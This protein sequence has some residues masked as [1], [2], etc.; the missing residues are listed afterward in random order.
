[1]PVHPD[2]PTLDSAEGRELRSGLSARAKARIAGALYLIIIVGGAFA[3]LGVRERLVVSGDAAATAHNIV[4]HELLYRLGFAIEVFYLLCGVPLKFLLYDLFRVV[5]RNVALVMVL[6]AAIGA[7]I[8]GVMMLA[9]Y[10]PLLFLGGAGYLGAFSAAQLQAAAYL[11]LRLFDYGYMI[12]LAF[13]GCFCLLIGY[14]I[15][16]STFFPRLV[17]PLLAIEG[18]LYLTNS[19]AHFLA[20]AVG[21]QVYPF[22]KLSGIGEV[23][24][25]L[26]LL[27]VGVNAS[28]WTT[29]AAEQVGRRAPG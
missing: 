20:P 1:M 14:L 8:Q 10:A 15:V 25:C 22:L 3:Q 5:N 7:A 28:R 23:S 19:F 29:Q 24:F 12:A 16:R 11:S 13:F 27:V 6:F 17:G 4:A 9:H 18:V 2:V 21:D 26:C